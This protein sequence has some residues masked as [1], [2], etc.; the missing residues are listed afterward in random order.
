MLSSVEHDFVFISSRPVLM[1]TL[2]SFLSRLKNI[3]VVRNF[4]KLLSE[5]PRYSL[6][7]E[8]KYFLSQYCKVP[9]LVDT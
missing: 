7:V 1:S 6:K 5:F 8:F 3:M 2:F 4:A 9:S